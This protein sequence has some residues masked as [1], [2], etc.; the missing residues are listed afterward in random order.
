MLTNRECQTNDLELRGK[1]E[2]IERL[3]KENHLLGVS[4]ASKQGI[5]RIPLDQAVDYVLEI[6][7]ISIDVIAKRQAGEIPVQEAVRRR[8]T[9]PAQ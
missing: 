1:L 2:E 8:Q 3:E 6:T 4:F 7:K 9:N 5:G